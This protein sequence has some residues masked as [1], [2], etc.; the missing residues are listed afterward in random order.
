MYLVVTLQFVVVLTSADR[1]ISSNLFD[2]VRDIVETVFTEHN[3]YNF[4][5]IVNESKLSMN[6]LSIG[7]MDTDYLF[8]VILKGNSETSAV[9]VFDNPRNIENI[10]KVD[11]IVLIDSVD[12]LQQ[13]FTQ[14]LVDKF[15]YNKHFLIVLIDGSCDGAQQ[16]FNFFWEKKIIN[17]KV[18]DEDKGNGTIYLKSFFPLKSTNCNDVKLRIINRFVDASFE[19]DIKKSFEFK[20]FD[21]NNCPIYCATYDCPPAVVMNEAENGTRL[22]EG[23]D[24]KIMRHLA[25]KLNF[26]LRFKVP[27]EGKWGLVHPNGSASGSMKMLLEGNADVIVSYYLMKPIRVRWMAPSVPYDFQNLVFVVPPGRRLTTIEKLYKIFNPFVWLTLTF[28]IFFLGSIIT[29]IN[30]QSSKTRILILGND[31]KIPFLNFI[32]TLLGVADSVKSVHS[33]TRF[34]WMLFTIACLILRWVQ[35]QSFREIL[36]DKESLQ[37]HL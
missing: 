21:M 12:K 20:I 11:T 15:D 2:A 37:K 1:Q 30:R 32:S 5:S 24:V 25:E 4:I 33:K 7:E 31:T 29:V 19:T 10:T 23:T 36:L 26:D 14:N 17:V 3:A 22:F 13:I 8:D 18:L 34:V 9:Y 6:Q 27:Q 35:I 16:I 28:V